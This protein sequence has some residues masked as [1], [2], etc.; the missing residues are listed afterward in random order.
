MAYGIRHEDWV[1]VRGEVLSEPCYRAFVNMDHFSAHGQEQQ[2]VDTEGE[3][4]ICGAGIVDHN[5]KVQSLI[6]GTFEE[7]AK[8]LSSEEHDGCIWLWPTARLIDFMSSKGNSNGK[9]PVQKWCSVTDKAT[10]EKRKT[11]E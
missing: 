3:P 1:Y 4:T 2:I 6:A 11:A 7:A 8:W 10:G 5:Y 9:P